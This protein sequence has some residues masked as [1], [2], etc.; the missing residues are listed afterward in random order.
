V[1]DPDTLDHLWCVLT[2]TGLLEGT[3]DWPMS[4][5]EALCDAGLLPW[6]WGLW[7]SLHYWS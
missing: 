3:W 6:Y 2:Q 5:W 7:A 1:A 4:P